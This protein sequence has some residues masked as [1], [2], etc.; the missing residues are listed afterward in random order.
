[1]LHVYS[2]CMLLWAGSGEHLNT[3]HGGGN[4]QKRTTPIKRHFAR[5]IFEIISPRCPVQVP[6][7][8]AP[9]WLPQLINLLKLLPQPQIIVE[10]M[11]ANIKQYCSNLWKRPNLL[12]YTFNPFLSRDDLWN[13]LSK[14]NV[15]RIDVIIMDN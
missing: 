7:W 9:R 6:R 3:Y 15:R 8:D 2:T 4:S 13:S 5:L 12:N 11:K 10:G 1:M 14:W